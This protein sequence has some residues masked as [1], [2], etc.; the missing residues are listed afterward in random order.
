MHPVVKTI[1]FINSV[2]VNITCASKPFITY[3]I[4]PA[5]PNMHT[6]KLSV[7]T[8]Y[9]DGVCVAGETPH[10]FYEMCPVCAPFILAFTQL[11]SLDLS[12]T[13]TAILGS[14]NTCGCNNSSKLML[15]SA[16]PRDISLTPLAQ[17]H[18]KEHHPWR[19]SQLEKFSH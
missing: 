2:A 5:K 10:S 3:C 18:W 16:V 15:L 17:L 4:H 1:Q 6:V 13:S 8:R 9:K 12:Q 19:V 14:N 7:T 11:K